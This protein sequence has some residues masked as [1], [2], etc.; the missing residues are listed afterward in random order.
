MR[1][2]IITASFPLGSIS[3]SSINLNSWLRHKY[4][5]KLMWSILGYN[6]SIAATFLE[7]LMKIHRLM[8]IKKLSRLLIPL[9]RMVFISHPSV[10]SFR[11]EWLYKNWVYGL[12]TKLNFKKKNSTWRIKKRILLYILISVPQIIDATQMINLAR[13]I[14]TVWHLDHW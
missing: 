4:D 5:L 10:C 11:W 12:K 13:N 3:F 9:G 2:C 1:P 7:G 8:C 6:R 14:K